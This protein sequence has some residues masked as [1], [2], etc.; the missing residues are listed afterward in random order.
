VGLVTGAGSGI[1]RA[2]ALQILRYGGNVYACDMNEAAMKD[3]FAGF[4]SS[5]VLSLKLDV[6]DGAAVK[7]LADVC[8]KTGLF[9]VVNSAGVAAPP[10]RQV[11]I[12]QGIVEADIDASVV[13]IIDINLL[14]T[15][16]VNASLFDLIFKSNGT[17]VNIASVAGRVA[18]P[19]MGAYNISKF[20]VVAYSGAMRR[21]LA[22]Y[23]IKVFCIEPGFANTNILKFVKDRVQPDLSQTRL[24][25]KTF[26]TQKN[27][28]NQLYEM[29]G[30]DRMQT[31]DDVAAR[32]LSCLFA[33]S[34][35]PPHIVC[36][37]VGRYVFYHLASMMPHHWFDALVAYQLKKSRECEL[38]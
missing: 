32:I 37:Y 36:D 7:R 23:G 9:A 12:V 25:E 26:A 20:G 16:R 35:V 1:G 31:A 27:D 19:G 14:G 34:W 6:R 38:K 29:M 8:S 15:M 10:G 22:P 30:A 2:T 13:P 24:L 21:E 5:R 33:S 28:R 17:F 11:P 18:M 3:A 4:D